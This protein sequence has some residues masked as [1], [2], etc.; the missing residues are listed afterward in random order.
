MS[1][2]RFSDLREGDVIYEDGF[3]SSVQVKV[4]DEPVKEINGEYT[5][6]TF[7]G[8]TANGVVPYLITEGMEHYG[9]RLSR[10]PNYFDVVALTEG[11]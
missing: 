5:Q 7:N 6:W 8:Q 9:P 2:L 10:Q 11:P 3:G 1:Y 4:L